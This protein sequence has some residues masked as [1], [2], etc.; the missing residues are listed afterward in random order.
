MEG[1]SEPINISIKTVRE[2]FHK[3]QIN[4]VHINNKC[5]AIP[6]HI[7]SKSSPFNHNFINYGE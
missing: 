5:L 3:Q 2:A 4:W 7:K 6:D 1:K